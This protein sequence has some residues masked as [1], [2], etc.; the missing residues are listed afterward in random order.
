MTRPAIPSFRRFTPSSVKTAP[1]SGVPDYHGIQSLGDS[2]SL[3]EIGVRLTSEFDPE[4]L[5]PAGGRET[6][7][8][9]D[10]GVLSD[11]AGCRPFDAGETS[12]PVARLRAKARGLQ[13]YT[14][15]RYTHR[16]LEIVDSQV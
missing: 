11:A 5:L 16:R 15:Q 8:S 4:R 13:L 2:A 1:C 9:I 6:G 7:E 10:F 3:H 14:R 12:N